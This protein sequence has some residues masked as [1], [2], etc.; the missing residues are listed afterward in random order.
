MKKVYKSWLVRFTVGFAA[1]TSIRLVSTLL[2]M[3]TLEK[4]YKPRDF[5]KTSH[6]ELDQEIIDE[7]PKYCAT[8]YGLKMDPINLLFVG[9]ED[10]I[11]QAFV[12]AGWQEA[13]PST[14]VHAAVGLL[15]AIFRRPYRRGPFMPLFVNIGLQDLAF[16]K[17]GRRKRFASRHHI[18]IWRTGHILPGDKSLWVAAATHETGLKIVWLPT[19]LVHKLDPDLDDERDYIAG[20][21]IDQG[22]LLAGEYSINPPIVRQKPKR[23]PHNDKYYSDGQAKLVEFI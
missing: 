14:P 5:R 22:N 23:N 7:L 21:M 8:A 11:K 20:D 17:T 1:L 19:F 2:H 3:T 18:R 4:I 13:H 12:A 9:G 6:L 16:A 10:S 15:A